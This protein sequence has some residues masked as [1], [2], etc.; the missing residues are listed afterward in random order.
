M[1]SYTSQNIK[2]IKSKNLGKFSNNISNISSVQRTKA[3][4][5]VKFK[6]NFSTIIEVESYKKYNFNNYLNTKSNC[7]NCSCDIF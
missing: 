6:S 2:S 1:T 3:K 4:K 7:V 5:R